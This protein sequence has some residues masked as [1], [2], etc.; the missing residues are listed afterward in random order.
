MT[1]AQAD[2]DPVGIGVATSPGSRADLDLTAWTDAPGATLT[3][4]TATLHDGSDTATVPSLT[5]TGNGHWST[6][7]RSH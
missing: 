7:S 1:A 4:V 3:S 2:P 6:A 5:T